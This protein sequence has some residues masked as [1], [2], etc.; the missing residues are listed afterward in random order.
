[1]PTVREV[2]GTASDVVMWVQWCNCKGSNRYCIRCSD[3][4]ATVMEL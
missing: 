2:T 1:M 3:V 4:V